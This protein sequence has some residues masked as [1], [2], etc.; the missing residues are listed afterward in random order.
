MKHTKS[1][2]SFKQ[3]NENTE[4]SLNEDR[5]Q[6]LVEFRDLLAELNKNKSAIEKSI[7]KLNDRKA[8]DL[9]KQMMD[10]FNTLYKLYR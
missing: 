9:S 1:L 4:A 8:E 5:E 6:Q 3:F 2:E 10:L 7:V